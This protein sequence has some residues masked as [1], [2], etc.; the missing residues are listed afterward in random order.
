M[1]CSTRQECYSS[2]VKRWV[3]WVAHRTYISRRRQFDHPLAMCAPSQ[4]S[5]WPSALPKEADGSSTK[6]RALSVHVCRHRTRAFPRWRTFLCRSM[7]GQRDDDCCD[8]SNGSITSSTDQHRS[9]L[10]SCCNVEA[11][12]Q[13]HSRWTELVWYAGERVETVASD[14][15]QGIQYRAY[16]LVSST[17]C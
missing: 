1:P 2:S 14:F 5:L 7:A 4:L 15:Q 8:F 6:E 16:H 12:F 10:Q 3:W 13:T 11:L 17:C 9:L